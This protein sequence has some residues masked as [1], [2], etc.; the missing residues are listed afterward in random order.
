LPPS[1]AVEV[2]APP[3]FRYVPTFASSLGQ[4]AIDLAEFAGLSLDGWQRDVLIGAM[5]R[6]R[7]WSAM[8]VAL[9]VPRQNGKG[10]ILEAR[11]LAGLYLIDSDELQTHTAHRFDTCLDHF[12]RIR[13]LIEGNDTLLAKVRSIRDSNGKES[14]ELKDG[15]R[16]AFKARSKGSGRGFS[17]DAV[18]FDEAFWLQDL[19]SL[20]PS[21]SAR[22]DPQI[23]YTSSAPLPRSES[24][25][26]REII[27][28]GRSLCA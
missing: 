8:E 28:R 26:L 19:G 21:L 13:G 16:L 12:R 1:A 24:D 5:G 22:V 3:R 18:Y 11:Q 20:V 27:R 9:I 2:S 10:A 7:R 6:N 14:I 15:S 25:R 23:W 17:G 4:D